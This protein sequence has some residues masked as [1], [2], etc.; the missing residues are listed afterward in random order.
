MKRNVY[1]LLASTALLGFN[2]PGWKTDADGNLVKDADGNPIWVSATGESSVKGDTISRLNGEAANHRKRAETA[3]AKLATY[4]GIDDPEAARAALQTVRDL[5]DGDLINKGKLDEVRAEITKQYE[6]KISEAQTA[7]EK[8]TARANNILLESAFNGSEFARSR[9]A[10][11]LEM[12][13]ATFG[14][15]FKV[16]GDKIVAF[17]QQ[18]NQIYSDKA[19]GEPASF[20]EALEKIVT[21]WKHKDTI[22]KAPESGGTGGNGG[23]GSRGGGRTYTRDDF[24]KLS[25]A[26]Q[27]KVAAQAATGEVQIVD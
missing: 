24:A 18:G 14:D 3:E 16:E 26:E 13:R 8:A 23:G 9:L 19:V 11:P 17:D 7:A 22:L 12:V 20:D 2:N 25:P 10:V 4:E 6:T 1:A 27:S 15:R 5:K 21:T